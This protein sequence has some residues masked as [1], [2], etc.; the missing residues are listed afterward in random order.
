MAKLKLMFGMGMGVQAG[1]GDATL[2]AFCCDAAF[3]R[4]N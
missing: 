1:T 3:C 4:Q 2:F